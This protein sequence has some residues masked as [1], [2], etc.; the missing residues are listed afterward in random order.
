MSVVYKNQSYENPVIRGFHP[1]PSICRVGED[2]YLVTSS[3]EYVPGIPVFH[4]R[5]LVNWT[6]IGACITRPEQIAALKL[7]QAVPSGGIWAPTIRWRDGVFYVTAPADQVGNFI[8]QT[9]DPAGEWSN[10]VFVPMGGIDPSILFEDGH[11]YYCT[12]YRAEK[13][14]G[15]AVYPG[16][17][18]SMAEIDP[19]S[20]ELLSEIR[21]LW[22]GTGGGFLEAPHLY[23][24]GDWYY[25]LTAEGGTGLNHMETAARS[26][27][28]W[29]PYESCEENPILT[30][31]N[32]TTKTAACCGHGDLVE[33]GNGN[34]WMVHIGTRPAN[35]W[36]SHT[37]RETWLMPVTWEHGWPKVGLSSKEPGRSHRKETGPLWREQK[38]QACWYADLS[39]CIGAAG[40]RNPILPDSCWMFIR[41][42]K[43]GCYAA[44]NGTLYL[45][46]SKTRIEDAEG[47]PTAA[48]ICQPDVECRFFAEISPE[49][50]EVGVE[51]GVT[52]YLSNRFFYRMSLVREADGLYLQVQKQ[53]DD[54]RECVYRKEWKA[55][56]RE[57]IENGGEDGEQELQKI[58]LEIRALRY[59][60]QFLADETPCARAATRFLSC[61]VAGK[62]FTG[63]M[64]GVY[65]QQMALLPGGAGMKG[66]DCQICGE[67]QPEHGQNRMAERQAVQMTG[68]G[69]SRE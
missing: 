51:A 14:A 5:D 10:P 48:F 47:S 23:H 17:M 41:N 54:F 42:P 66:R 36:L 6:Q 3:F 40:K 27:N 18:I 53:A 31:R 55:A 50:I 26:R 57:L 4:S 32:D 45:K 58:H 38:L 9:K 34:W 52:A 64:L 39:D 68:I 59:E 13:T 65:A 37:G 22:N 2:Y 33:D 56:R 7:D 24:V 60:Y 16:E 21:P 19:D 8:V 28:L 43:A 25:L 15:T 35:N 1:D 29:G 12:N 62:C 11:A 44:E 30:N 20:G 63:T 67:N 46:P 61:E 69:W 49:S